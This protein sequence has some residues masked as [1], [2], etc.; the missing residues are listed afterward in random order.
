MATAPQAPPPSLQFNV[1]AV[2]MGS[3]V[4]VMVQVGDNVGLS[5]SLILT[6]AAAKALARAV[7][8]GV[9][10]AEKTIIKPQSAIAT[11]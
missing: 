11:A 4:C 6:Q 10:I 1:Q 9:D 2:Q 5:M 7:R 8:E 3:E